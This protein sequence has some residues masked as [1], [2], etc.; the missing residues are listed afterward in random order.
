MAQKYLFEIDNSVKERMAL[1]DPGMH[2]YFGDIF[3]LIMD[4]APYINM[5]VFDKPMLT[6]EH[7]LLYVIAGSAEF[8]IGYEEYEFTQGS[9]VLIPRGSVIITKGVSKTYRPYSMFFN[10]SEVDEQGLMPITV[11]ALKLSNAERI[12]VTNYYS[13]IDQ[14][15]K[16]RAEGQRDVTFLVVSLLHHLRMIIDGYSLSLGAKQSSTR[17]MMIRDRFWALVSQ[18]G[19]PQ[20]N[21][22]WYANQLNLSEEYLRATIRKQ[23][24]QP[25]MKWINMATIREARLLLMAPEHYPLSTIAE[26]LFFSDASQFVKFF[27]RETGETPT[28]FR[29]RMR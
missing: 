18:P 26:R 21:V 20:R 28:C 6:R 23:T 24:L 8:Q 3:S 19:A 16:K 22:G 7:E 25:P 5:V 4:F 10:F 11:T 14:L 9:M 2:N 27:K 12:V 1:L 15:I 17:G 13:L 29:K